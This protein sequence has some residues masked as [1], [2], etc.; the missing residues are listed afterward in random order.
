MNRAVFLTIILSICAFNCFSQNCIQKRDTL[1][2]VSIDIR[3]KEEYPVAMAGVVEDFNSVSF[4]KDNIEYFL[5][6]FYSNCFYVPDLYRGYN[7]VILQCIGEDKG[8]KYLNNHEDE[9]SRIMNYLSKHSIRGK[10]MLNSGETVFVSI[11]QIGGDFLIIEKD[12]KKIRN[13]SIEANIYSIAEI[14]EV[15]V[16][17]KIFFCKKP[18]G[19]NIER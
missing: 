15:Y 12:S 14:Q 11:V 17:F 13:N 2:Y 18:R 4:L 9:G 3:S 16:P 5:K 10:F 6:S 19:I 8:G 1:Y 7:D